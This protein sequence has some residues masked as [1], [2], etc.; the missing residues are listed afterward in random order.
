MALVLCVECG[1]DVSSLAQACPG[2]GCPVAHSTGAMT[3]E[4]ESQV[5]R[6]AAAFGSELL[7]WLYVF[8]P[9]I[10]LILLQLLIDW[11]KG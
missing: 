11:L 6:K 7:F 2:C 10:G 5:G 9:V 8:F 3:A 1:R 4:A